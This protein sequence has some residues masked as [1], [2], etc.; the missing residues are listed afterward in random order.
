MRRLLEFEARNGRVALD[1]DRIVGVQQNRLPSDYPAR[2]LLDCEPYH[3]DVRE[4]FR[5]VQHV[6]ALTPRD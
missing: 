5:D 2:V 3:V 6:I 4:G 1:V